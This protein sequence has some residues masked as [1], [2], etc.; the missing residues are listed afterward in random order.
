MPIAI[1]AFAALLVPPV[2]EASEVGVGV[3]VAEFVVGDVARLV[4]VVGA[5]AKVVGMASEETLVISDRELVV[6]VDVV[7]RVVA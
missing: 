7:I 1:P 5:T 2:F 4:V 3:E 6:G